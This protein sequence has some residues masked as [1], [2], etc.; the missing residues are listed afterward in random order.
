[1]QLKQGIGVESEILRELKALDSESLLIDGKEIKA[2]QCYHFESDP[3][4][5]L[6]NTNCPDTLKSRLNSILSKYTVG[7]EGRTS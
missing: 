5:I 7:Y 1:M 3:A 6:Y 4:H 2:S